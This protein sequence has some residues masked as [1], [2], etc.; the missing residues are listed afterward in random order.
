MI[1]ANKSDN[2]NTKSEPAATKSDTKETK[3]ENPEPAKAIE[4]K[5]ADNSVEIKNEVPKVEEKLDLHFQME[6]IINYRLGYSCPF[7]LGMLI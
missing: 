5:S 4:A 7:H 2:A 3:N 6:L 1:S